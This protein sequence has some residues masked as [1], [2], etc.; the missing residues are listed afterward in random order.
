MMAMLAFLPNFLFAEVNKEDAQIERKPV[1]NI[2]LGIARENL[3]SFHVPTDID[4]AD[5][6][7]E[8]LDAPKTKNEK[9]RKRFARLRESFERLKKIY[10]KLSKT[11]ED[12]LNPTEEAKRRRGFTLL[13]TYRDLFPLKPST[14][15]D[16]TSRKNLELICGPQNNPAHYLAERTDRTATE[17]GKCIWLK[18]FVQPRCDKRIIEEQ[19]AVR[20]LVENNDLLQKLN[21]ELSII[22]SCEP[23]L[24][25]FW[26]DNEFATRAKN[27][28]LRWFDGS[29]SAHFLRDFKNI[30]GV[31][32]LLGGTGYLFAKTIKNNPWRE[33]RGDGI[34]EVLIRNPKRFAT[35]AAFGI[36]A[37]IAI[38]EILR[39]PWSYYR[40]KNAVL[41]RKC[42]Q[43]KMI[44]SA[45]YFESVKKIHGLLKEHPSLGDSRT[46]AKLDEALTDLQEIDDDEIRLLNLLESK[47]FKG[48]ASALSHTG[49]VAVAYR[50]M[51]EIHK[52][53]LETMIAVGKIDACVSAANLYKEFEQKDISMC[54]PEFLFDDQRDSAPA[55]RAKQFW[56]PCVDFE[57]VVPSSITI[58]KR[59]DKRQNIIVTGPNTSGK[60][61]ITRALVYSIIMAQSIGIAPAEELSF[62]PFSK[63]ITHLGT[64]DD[65]HTGHPHFKEGIVRARDILT[66]I[67]SESLRGRCL[68]NLDEFFMGTPE[69][70]AQAAG[71]N[72]LKFLGKEK[73]NLCVATTHFPYITKLEKDT[74]DF[75]NYKIG[76]RLDNGNIIY[77]YQFEPGVSDQSI[78]FQVLQKEGLRVDFLQDVLNKKVPH[79]STDN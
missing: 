13:K 4:D 57:K 49:R 74:K 58:G 36:S 7:I 3:E 22:K 16:K 19:E 47:T 42:L 63:I 35:G 62:T 23:A 44:H 12:Q 6:V 26:Q 8:K 45:S 79:K 34:P 53:F 28:R 20:Y 70:D 14:V 77:S 38:F 18:K 66:I 39:S 48:E 40:L 41:L 50:L 24:F 52:G 27:L 60:S 5:F 1:H 11:L 33:E 15:L 75:M 29:T 55:I 64:A 10:E 69:N 67:R 56:N 72:F 54:F 59:F 51:N 61:T 43:T 46:M 21:Q 71:Y 65:I 17:M 78:A 30:F 76:V 32:L 31:P 68:T 37:L 73:H 9:K 25:S 2:Y